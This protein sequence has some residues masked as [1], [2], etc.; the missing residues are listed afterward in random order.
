VAEQGLDKLLSSLDVRLHAVALCEVRRGQR[1][2][3][4]PFDVA[5]FHYV[6][7]GRGQLEVEGARPRGFGPNSILI[8]PPGRRK[9]VGVDGDNEVTDT[10]AMLG[11]AMTTDGL[12]RIGHGDAA[13]E[14]IMAC[15][16]LSATWGGSLGL[17]DA[18]L[19]PVVEDVSGIADVRRAFEIMLAEQAEPDLGARALTE[20]LMKQCLI[21]ALRSLARRDGE[22]A[23][24]FVNRADPRLM[25]AA[26][27]VM[28][29][30][31]AAHSVTELATVAGMSR[32]AFAKK[33]ADTFRDSP[34]DFVQKTRLHHAARLLASTPMPVKL[35]ASSV[36]FASRSH[37]SRAFRATYG[38]SPSDYRARGEA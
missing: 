21:L 17:F 14:L 15:G 30:P 31:A 8:V 4:E 11:A 18:L 24:L 37:F 34:M 28:A 13:P 33:F 22:G 36:G 38:C 19:E 10:P 9:H 6:L 12:I 2:V 29:R 20:T 1:L 32:S 25:R 23:A 7:K 3:F 35:V 5:V 27:A 26:E 16:F